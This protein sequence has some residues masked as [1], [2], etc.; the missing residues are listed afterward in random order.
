MKDVVE[1]ELSF[2]ELDCSVLPTSM[3]L[4]IIYEDKYLLIL[5]K[6]S[7]IP[8]HPSMRH[9]DNSLANGVKFYFNEI[10]T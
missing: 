4:D 2:D 9:F 5:N 1:V 10:R 3:G 8:V 7:G 6:P